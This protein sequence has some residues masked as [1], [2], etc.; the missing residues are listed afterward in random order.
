[1]AGE[2]RVDAE[3]QA[4]LNRNLELRK[5]NAVQQIQN[6]NPEGGVYVDR[7]IQEQLD[8]EGMTL[9]RPEEDYHGQ[10]LVDQTVGN[11]TTL[12]SGASNQLEKSRYGRNFKRNWSDILGTVGRV[13]EYMVDESTRGGQSTPGEWLSWGVGSVLRDR[14]K[15]TE[16]TGNA[17]SQ[18]KIGDKGVDPRI[19]KFA[20]GEA[21][22][23]LAT[24]GLAGISKT[25]AK[26]AGRLPPPPKGLV[27]ATVG[28]GANNL[29]ITPT[30]SEFKPSNV[31]QVAGNM[32]AANWQGPIRAMRDANVPSKQIETRLSKPYHKDLKK[33]YIS[34]TLEDLAKDKG[35]W[36]TRLMGRADD[37]AQGLRDWRVA[38]GKGMESTGLANIQRKFYDNLTENPLDAFKQI[39]D[40]NN[41]VRKLLQ[42]GFNTLAGKEWHHIFGNKDAAEF[43]LTTVA[44]D[45]YIAVNLFH[46]MKKLKLSTSGV[47]DN[48]A[49][50]SMK[51]HRGKGGYHS[52][53]KKLGLENKGV[54]EGALQFSSYAKAV[55]NGIL[56]G[57]TDINELFSMLEVYSR[58]NKVQRGILKN[59]FSAEIISEQGP[60]MQYIQGV[61][62]KSQKQ[63]L[64]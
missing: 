31:F 61:S 28:V 37:Y 41:P 48:I 17:L 7:S 25:I 15:Y 23:T 55:S 14:E 58:L 1:M 62:D 34:M 60:I 44:Q 6:L 42:K 49:T 21:L 26:T 54:K 10:N 16:A 43:M 32:E 36:L 40:P 12:V 19:T 39:Y 50:M 47:P 35:G 57:S 4:E 2:F 51:P 13:G 46:Y 9:I 22:D 33:G 45:P 53:S 5:R 30:T 63:I 64:K 59:N 18:I 24:G 3:E 52:Y 11:V 8:T 27:P 20:A 29:K 56:D 38:K